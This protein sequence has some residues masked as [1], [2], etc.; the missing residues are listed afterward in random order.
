MKIDRIGEVVFGKERPFLIADA[1]VNHEGSLDKALEMVEAAAAAGADMIKFQA[2]KAER[3]ATRQSP[4][5]WDRRQEPTASQYELFK[6][7]DGLDARDYR[8]IA[9]HC[10]KKGILFAATAFDETFVDLLDPLMPVHK[11]ASADITNRLLLKKIASKGKPVIL[12]TGAAYLSE[13]DEAVRFLSENGVRQV[14]LLHCVLEYPTQPGN[15]NLLSIAFLKSAFPDQTIGWSDHI[16][17][18][19]GCL[20]LITAWMLGAEIIEKHFTLDKSLP[21]NDNYHAVDP[22]DIV[23]FRKKTQYVHGL[24][25]VKQKR[26]LPCEENAR[27]YARR[28]LVAR[29]AIEA[30]TPIRAEMLT[31][32]R[33]GTGMAPMYLDWLEGKKPCVSIAED[34]VIQWEMFLGTQENCWKRPPDEEPGFEK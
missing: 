34:E 3:I 4:A 17:P 30:G 26:V 13:I 29:K 11:V 6:K 28:S 33:P 25:G 10:E 27:K 9:E 16:R 7:Y 31:A 32:K 14:A 18:E 8:R 23:E 12:S 15:A 21:G 19:Y 24:L 20:A 2:Y 22:E 1:G 5:Y